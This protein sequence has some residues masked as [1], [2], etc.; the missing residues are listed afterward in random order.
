MITATSPASSRARRGARRPVRLGVAVLTVGT[1]ALLTGCDDSPDAPQ[2]PAETLAEAL[3]TG[4]F[5]EVP[6]D[7]AAAGDLEAAVANLHEPFGEI[8]PEI[9]VGEIALDVPEEDSPQAPTAT[10]PL[11]HAWDLSELGAPDETWEYDTEA[12][13]TYSREAEEWRLE[14]DVE[15]VLADYDGAEAVGISTV[16]GDRGR[17]MDRHGKAI[18]RDREIIRVGLDK[19]RLTDDDS[20][21]SEKRQR[22]AARQ[23]A[24]LVDID[25]ESYA[26][27]VVGYG[28]EAFVEAIPLRADSDRVTAEELESVPGAVGREDTM[29]LAESSD[30]APLLLGRVGDVTA[31]DLEEDET[32]QT[33][34]T[35][36]QSGMQGTYDD[37]LRGEGGLRIHVGGQ[38]QHT[39]EASAGDDVDTSLE[40]RLQQLAQDTIAEQDSAAALV[41]IKPSSGEVLAAA[42]H[43][44][45]S[46]WVPTA[47]Q[48]T[49]AP[50]SSFKIVSSLTMLRDGIE[51]DSTVQ[52]PMSTTVHGQ[53]FNN[54]EGFSPEYLGDVTFQEAVATSCNTVFVD[55]WDDTTSPELQQAAADLGLSNELQDI[56]MPADFGSV[57]EDSERNELGA[58]LFGQGV[59]ETSAL[60]MATVVSSVAAGETVHPWLVDPEDQQGAEEGSDE[61]SEEGSEGDS[62][63]SSENSEESGL[64]SQEAEDLRT[65]LSD[66]VDYGTLETMEEIPG[67]PVLAKTGTAQAGSGE[68]MYAHTWVVAVQD[69]L[70]VAIFVEEGEYGS[71]TNGPLLHDF[72]TGAPDILE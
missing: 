1:L 53:A 34:D 31:E 18:V 4:D 69:D 35:I 32:L 67:A 24:E 14:A 20:P 40:P 62:D 19:T 63:E 59:V 61:D 39:V 3:T 47:T 44:P 36:G 22:Q 50:G 58:N 48:A 38:T 49:Y 60:G 70:A 2:A 54:H 27:K 51:P 5:S 42:S 23:L 21:A 46:S 17:I 28:D 10:V 57:P 9:T 11:H 8:D 72:L 71:S 26:D 43:T 13:F 33:G 16:S 56:G 41:A 55:R 37:A 66:T 52:C 12:E 6:V 65:L 29:P 45:E 64:T 7:G 15:D 25:A 30:F 68:D